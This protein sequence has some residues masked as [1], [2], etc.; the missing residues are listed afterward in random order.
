MIH[1]EKEGRKK[2]D[3]EHY[4]EEYMWNSFMM[5]EIFE[6]RSKLDSYVQST[7]DNKVI[8]F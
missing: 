5:C 7:L 1:H 4:L 2:I 3:L 8:G 6:F